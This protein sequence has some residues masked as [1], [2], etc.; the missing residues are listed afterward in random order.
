MTGNGPDAAAIPDLVT[1]LNAA[2]GQPAGIE[3]KKEQRRAIIDALNGAVT[4]EFATIPTYLIAL[5]TIKDERHPIANS[6]RNILQEEMLHL[7]LVCNMLV[8][9]GGEPEISSAAPTYPSKL[10]LGVHPELTVPLGRFSPKMLQVFMEIERPEH[11]DPMAEIAGHEAEDHADFTIGQLYGKLLTAFRELDP[12]F[13]QDRQV[14]GPLSWIPILSLADVE[15]AIDIIE[16]Q[17]EGSV[18]K[19]EERHGHLAHYWRFYEMFHL[20]RWEKGRDGTWGLGTPIAFD[21]DADVW[22]MADI[23][24][25]GYRLDPTLEPDAAHLLRQFNI[26]YSNLLDYLQATW[27]GPSGQA[28]ILKAIEAMFELERYAKPLIRMPRPEGGLNY[29]PDFRYIPALERTAS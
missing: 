11:I 15:E 25:G 19:P 23:P 21:F 29:G 14:T 4:L 5:W 24:E 1:R 18:G 13:S 16:T 26:T 7:A 27:S 10:P 9:I 28:M 3:D 22:P 8:S 2:A 6:L 20:K 12:E 17:G